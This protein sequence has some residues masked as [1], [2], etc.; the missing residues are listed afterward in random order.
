MPEAKI[1]KAT[2]EEVAQLTHESLEKLVAQWD[3]TVPLY[4][5][6]K[7]EVDGVTDNR[8][9]SVTAIAEAIRAG[10]AVPDVYESRPAKKLELAGIERAL[11]GIQNDLVDGVR[12][13][14]DRQTNAR[15][16]ITPVVPLRSTVTGEEL[17]DAI[18]AAFDAS[19]RGHAA[20]EAH[21]AD[22]RRYDEAF[23]EYN[24]RRGQHLANGVD[25]REATAAAKAEMGERADWLYRKGSI[26]AI[27][28]QQGAGDTF[29]LKTGA[30]E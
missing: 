27:V 23:A 21:I 9:S 1:R 11:E 15:G 26:G 28:G 3:A 4:R 29:N 24:E 18:V 10:K 25:P 19:D 20:S 7:R 22:D 13:T 14:R 12:L 17:V 6:K 2:P 30:Q 5:Q 16:P 8:D